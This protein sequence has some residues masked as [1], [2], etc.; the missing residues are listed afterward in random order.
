MGMKQTL[1]AVTE[2]LLLILCH[3]GLGEIHYQLTGQPWHVALSN[4]S[5]FVDFLYPSFGSME[6]VSIT[7]LDTSTNQTLAKKWLPVNESQGTVEFECIY[8]R[9]AGEYQFWMTIDAQLDNDTQWSTDVLQVNWPEFNMEVN[10]STNQS[11]FQ[12]CVFTNEY[13]CPF[14]ENP[15]VFYLTVTYINMHKAGTNKVLKQVSKDISITKAQC[16]EFQCPPFDQQVL[17]N[18][19]LSS[20]TNSILLSRGPL[21][22][23]VSSQYKLHF[24]TTDGVH[25]TSVME[26]YI[27][28]PPC[29]YL[30]GRVTVYK[31]DGRTPV[32]TSV[33]LLNGGS[34]KTEFSCSVFEPGKNRYCFRFVGGMVSSLTSPRAYDCTE[35]QRETEQW[36]L[37]HTWSPCSVSCG[38]GVRERFRECLSSLTVNCT[39]PQKDTS[40]C[41]FEDCLATTS[42]TTKPFP[43]TEENQNVS[44][45][46]TVAGISLCL[47]IIFAT[48]LFTVWRKLCHVQKCSSAVRHVSIHSPS[49]RKNSD[50]ENIYQLTQQQESFSENIEATPVISGERMPVS[51]KRSLNASHEQEQ[52]ILI[53]D[54]FQ[55]PGQKVLPPI[56]GYRL[57]QQQLKEMKIKGLT[58]ATKVYHVSQNPLNDTVVEACKLHLQ[59]SN[60][61][62]ANRMTPFQVKPP[63]LDQIITSPNFH[64]ER[65]TPRADFPLSPHPLTVSSSL[66]IGRPVNLKNLDCR[67]ETT[68]RLYYRNPNFRRTASFTGSKQIRPYRE[69]S[70]STI[71]PTQKPGYD[72]RIK[73]TD[74]SI[75][76]GLRPKSRTGDPGTQ[77]LPSWNCGVLACE[78]SGYCTKS[79]QKCPPC[80]KPDLVSHHRHHHRHLP[81]K[82]VR[83]QNVDVNKSQRGPSPNSK[84]MVKSRYQKNRG[85]SPTHYRQERCKSLPLDPD[86]GFYDNSTFGL[87]TSEQKMIDLPGY[88]GSNEEDDETSTLS[89]DN[90][91]I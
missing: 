84:T 44:N 87:T 22:F 32:H 62:E 89:V 7:L 50:E 49:L 60:G 26:V 11:T 77:K 79:D 3:S 18:L 74:Q 47:F 25:C 23:A 39:G 56:Y 70:M 5:A 57:A 6:N 30:E 38:D 33:I 29:I 35:I 37:W 71:T 21:S 54:S 9:Q 65:S 66:P 41:S 34:N 51:N 64:I 17:L 14:G 46:V 28:T 52:E 88:F 31:G 1:K 16:L 90:L 83:S 72:T 78:E 61:Q 81:V 8:F 27:N 20:F 53:N 58:E 48:V 36:S 10:A 24:G 45:I 12:T 73:G 76:R 86:Y 85:L 2:L 4:K 80:G 67:G 68:D 19:S 55:I 43:E 59:D 91:V 69:R 42:P 75:D 82:Q 63:F 40:P 15:P 13:V